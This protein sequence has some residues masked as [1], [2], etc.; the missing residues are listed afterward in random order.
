MSAI[1]GDFPFKILKKNTLVI[2]KMGYGKIETT[3]NILF[4]SYLKT[5]EGAEIDGYIKGTKSGG[6]FEAEEDRDIEE[7]DGLSLTIV[8]K[9]F[10]STKSYGKKKLF[11]PE[12]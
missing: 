12:V 6:K 3:N 1:N 9:P 10:G 8:L 4:K 7:S 11:G 5:E 2:S